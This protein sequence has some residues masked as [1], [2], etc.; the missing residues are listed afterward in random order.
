MDAIDSLRAAIKSYFPESSELQLSSHFATHRRFN[1]Y[2]KIT[3]D[4]SYLLYLNWDEGDR[5][6]LKCLEFSSADLLGGLIDSYPELGT[7][8]FNVG[9]PRSTVSFIYMDEDKLKVTDMKGAVDIRFD[10]NS[11][12]FKKLMESVDPELR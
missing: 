1:F 4:Y 11:T 12:T 2:F 7:K 6:T 10:W 5:F 8:T 3:S 9:K